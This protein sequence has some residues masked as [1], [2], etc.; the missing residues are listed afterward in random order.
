MTPSRLERRP[1]ARHI[2]ATATVAM[3]DGGHV[4]V[5]ASMPD[6]DACDDCTAL[7]DGWPTHSEPQR[8]T[9]AAA[10]A[11]VAVDRML[12]LALGRRHGRPTRVAVV[13]GRWP[14]CQFFSSR[15]RGESS[16]ERVMCAQ[17]SVE[18]VCR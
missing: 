7:P 13:V 2:D 16:S 9:P 17:S 12:D 11:S 14:S 18:P 1:E 15:Q 4:F 8:A 3:T 10:A 5:H 6:A